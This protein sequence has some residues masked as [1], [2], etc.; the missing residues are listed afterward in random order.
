MVDGKVGAMD[1]IDGVLGGY[2]N[3]EAKNSSGDKCPQGKSRGILF[4]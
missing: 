2:S 3:Q 4:N 1:D